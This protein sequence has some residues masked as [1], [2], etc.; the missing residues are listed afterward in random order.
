MI[1][2]D[3]AADTMYSMAEPRRVPKRPSAYAAQLRCRLDLRY[4][5]NR[6]WALGMGMY[7]RSNWLSDSEV[8]A[9]PLGGLTDTWQLT[10]ECRSKGIRHTQKI[11]T[12]HRTDC[13]PHSSTPGLPFPTRLHHLLPLLLLLNAHPLPPPSPTPYPPPYP[14]PCPRPPPPPPAPPSPPFS[15]S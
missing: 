6:H 4:T 2:R 10:Q 1:G 9:R 11:S 14:P 5:P 7:C 3:T 8:F 13:N 15:P 12:H